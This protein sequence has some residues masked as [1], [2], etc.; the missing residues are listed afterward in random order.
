MKKLV[1]LSLALL[2]IAGVSYAKTFTVEC[3]AGTGQCDA[4]SL[5]EYVAPVSPAPVEPK[6]SLVDIVLLVLSVF[7]LVAVVFIIWQQRHL[8]EQ[9]RWS[10]PDGDMQ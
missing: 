2:M 10:I 5:K 8:N 6:S 1:F 9:D 3:D 7:N 4:N